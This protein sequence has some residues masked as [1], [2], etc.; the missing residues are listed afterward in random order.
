MYYVYQI[1]AKYVLTDGFSRGAIGPQ[2][3]LIY[4][5][6]GFQKSFV[7]Y[8]LASSSK[9]MLYT[10]K[11]Y[12]QQDREYAQSKH[13]QG[14]GLEDLSYIRLKLG[15]AGSFELLNAAGSACE[16][17]LLGKYRHINLTGILQRQVIN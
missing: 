14:I 15:Q 4:T 17:Y 16:H 13:N 12:S 6:R 2:T 1:L 7:R 11:S 8:S 9:T 3:R 10:D 5:S